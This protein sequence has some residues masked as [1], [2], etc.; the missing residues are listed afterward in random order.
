MQQSHCLSN[1]QCTTSRDILNGMWLEIEELYSLHV[2][3]LCIFKCMCHQVHMCACEYFIACCTC[4]LFG[5]TTDFYIRFGYMWNLLFIR[6]ISLLFGKIKQKTNILDHF[7]WL[8]FLSVFVNVGRHCRSRRN[9]NFFNSNLM[10]R[11]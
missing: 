6:F 3:F 2:F 9:L 1:K 11:Q 4:V 10:R 5:S 8:F 7:S